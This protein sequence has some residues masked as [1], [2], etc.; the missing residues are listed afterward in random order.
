MSKISAEV[1]ADSV[2]NSHRITTMKV[3]M[4]RMIL[5]EF[6]TH[7]MFS[8]NSASSRAIPFKKMV[9]MV[10][11]SPFIPLKWMKEHS[12]MQGTE[13]FDDQER[14]GDM[15]TRVIS[16][17]LRERWLTARDTAV[18]AAEGL[19][20]AGP[21]YH[22]DGDSSKL[23]GKGR[24][25]SKQIC[26]RLLEPFM[27][28]TVLITA[29]EWQNFFALRAHEAAEIHMQALANEM[30]TAY[31]NSK[32]KE[33]T[34]EEWHIPYGDQINLKILGE[35][36]MS[37]IKCPGYEDTY[38]CELEYDPESGSFYMS[39][40]HEEVLKI[41]TA[42]CAQTSYTLLGDDDKP[43]DYAKL[44][45]LHD[46]LATAGHWSPFEH[47]ARAM[48]ETEYDHWT[49]TYP[50]I[51]KGGQYGV[52]REKGWCKNFRGWVQYRALF[53]NENKTDGRVKKV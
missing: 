40:L 7:R 51:T 12:G 25:L 52:V 13:Y 41:A 11:E 6:N 26:N 28:H 10:R 1:I 46:R 5:A 36:L 22:P 53:P 18:V 23:T 3:V 31:N 32:P 44:I 29:T 49:S 39:Y 24:G 4:P 42:R 17:Y 38:E 20:D 50:K 30:L 47:C 14:F 19:N 33:L 37:E 2:C 16:K 35:W 15:T 9:Q 48:T 27:Y 43:L 34:P 45:A 8:R 21:L